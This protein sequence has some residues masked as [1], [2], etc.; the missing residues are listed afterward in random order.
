MPLEIS[1]RNL[2]RLAV[3]APV[4]PILGQTPETAGKRSTVALV[5][6]DSR[7]Q[8]VADALTAIDHQIR[9][10][11]RTKK[12]VV[13]KV[14]NVSTTN[15]LAATHADSIHGILDY[16]QPRFKGPVYVVESSA[17]DTPQ[18][19]DTFGYNKIVQEHK[20]V[21]L[22]DLNREA[23]FKLV[24]MIDFDLHEKNARMAARLYDPEAFI[25]SAAMLKTHNVAVA[26]LSIK[27]MSLGAP[28]HSVDGE[29]WN[30]K[31]IVHNG[32]RQTL[33]NIFLA[34]QSMKPY[35]GA[36]VIDGY[37]GMEGNGPGSG[38]PVSSRLAIAS[39]DFV[40]A[41]RVAVEAMGINAAWMSTLQY[42]AQ[43]GLGQFD[44]D[45]IDVEGA[46][47]ADVQKKYR[48]HADI[49]RELEWMGPLTD[50][51]KKIG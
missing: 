51:P 9:P 38:T 8:N 34:A 30:D 4:Y 11:L 46:K 44:L 35:W 16:V 33:F 39:T 50:V 2:L 36:A 28:L 23:K 31:R 15:Q 13:I 22:I 42:C 27:N 21:S 19:F 48:L 17:G 12:T 45:K 43:G 7:R 49:E 40:A 47:I 3:L 1:R 6:G 32:L 5:K 24:P 10:V 26:T 29:R 37:E 25:I 20:N 14:N 18:G 41:D